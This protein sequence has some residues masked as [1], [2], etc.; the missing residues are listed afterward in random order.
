ML[1]KGLVGFSMALILADPSLAQMGNGRHMEHRMYD[2]AT[3]T[4]LSG[5]VDG[6]YE[7]SAKHRSG[8]T[9]YHLYLKAKD[10]TT[11]FVH[12]GPK[13]YYEEKDFELVKGD[14]LKIVASQIEMNG[15]KAFVAKEIQKGDKQLVIRDQSG[16]P[17]FSRSMPM[18]PRARDKT[19]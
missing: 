6:I 8:E 11:Y 4:S 18:G 13:S 2:P 15:E 9:G 19:Q 14:E 3:E 7:R 16:R 17:E 1:G 10:G 5:V 12:L